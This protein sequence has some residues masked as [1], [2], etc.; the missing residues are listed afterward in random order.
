[1]AGVPLPIWAARTSC[2]PRGC[3]SAGSPASFA[4]LRLSCPGMLWA[5]WVSAILTF[6]ARGI[7]PGWE[8]PATGGWTGRTQTQS[9]RTHFVL[10]DPTRGGETGQDPDLPLPVPL[11]GSQ[12]VRSGSHAP[13]QCT[14]RP[15]HVLVQTEEGGSPER[16]EQPGLPTQGKF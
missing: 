5:C 7:D 3:F 15:R 4:C 10:L 1:M 12:P 6:D 13:T 16:R 9:T 8:E 2:E 11:Q 14:G